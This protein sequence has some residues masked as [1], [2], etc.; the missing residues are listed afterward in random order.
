MSELKV[1]ADDDI[2]PHLENAIEE[3]DDLFGKYIPKEEVIKRVNEKIKEVRFEEGLV[4]EKKAMGM[5]SSAKRTIYIDPELDMIRLGSTMFHE[6]L[7]SI[8]TDKDNNIGFIK[9]YAIVNAQSHMYIPIGTA[10]EEGFVQYLTNIR[11]KKFAKAIVRIY[12]TEQNLLEILELDDERLTSIGLKNPE[13]IVDEIAL[14]TRHSNDEKDKKLVQDLLMSMDDRLRLKRN[15]EK[16]GKENETSEKRCI[17]IVKDAY[18]YLKEDVIQ[19]PE[20]LNEAL[21]NLNQLLIEFGRGFKM[22][23]R[24]V[25]IKLQD[26]YEMIE[27]LPDE[28]IEGAINGFKIRGFTYLKEKLE[29]AFEIIK[30]RN[31]EKEEQMGMLQKG[32][33]L[34]EC[35]YGGKF[36]PK[37]V[38]EEEANLIMRNIRPELGEYHGEEKMLRLFYRGMAEA[39]SRNGYDL[40]N[41]EISEVGDNI[42]KLINYDEDG[43]I[44][45]NV[46]VKK[47]GRLG[48]ESLEELRKVQGKVELP[49]I[50]IIIGE[51]DEIYGE[52]GEYYIEHGDGS[53]TLINDYIAIKD[54]TEKKYLERGEKVVEL[55]I[56]PE[57]IETLVN[58]VMKETN[59][60]ETMKDLYKT[61][62]EKENSDERDEEK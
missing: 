57:Q 33:K 2:R 18:M 53:K 11:N 9:K 34:M 16:S 62:N 1:I 56:T 46:F 31:A 30:F 29:T 13:K 20:E 38:S 14:A 23:T 51:N 7:H 28:C 42:Y 25:Q 39:I 17:E 21:I 3:F 4:K 47:K 36:A 24:D 37:K 15:K 41:I 32:S 44:S 54:L 35:I 19:S 8:R 40:K 10:L 5:W 45:T 55:I 50:N 12:E 22:S 59:I 27:G 6:M 58:L 48:E 49:D 61:K 26:V 52:N 60:M 43:K